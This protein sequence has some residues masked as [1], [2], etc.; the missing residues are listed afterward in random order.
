MASKLQRI[1]ELADKTAKT[2]TQNT[3]NWK[4]YLSVASRLYKDV[5][6]KG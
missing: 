3:D 1:S 6:C 5:C 2:V 4:Q